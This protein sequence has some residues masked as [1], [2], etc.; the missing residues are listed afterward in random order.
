MCGGLARWLRV[1]GV[2]ATYTPGIEDGELVRQALDEGR[3]VV[4]SD[5]K[6]L[7]RR[8]FTSGQLAS[9]LLPVGLRLD[10]QVRYVVNRL[11]PEVGFP[12]CALCNGELAAVQRTDV[13]DTVPARS[14]IWAKEFYRCQACGHVF[15]E[16]SHW[17]RI[18]AIRAEMAA[19]VAGE[20]DGE[21]AAGV[22]GDQLD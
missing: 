4:T 10:D 3:I 1:L 11:H 20:S 15:W 17:R 14:L 9:V 13:A 19:R 18:G 6:I 2:D 7:E 5:H 8:L 16:G 21:P 22:A 12:R